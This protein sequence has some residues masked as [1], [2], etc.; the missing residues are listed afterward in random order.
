MY[1]IMFYFPFHWGKATEMNHSFN[2]I[3]K[4]Q[5]R[6]TRDIIM[7]TALI[8]LQF[9]LSNELYKEDCIPTGTSTKTEQINKIIELCCLRKFARIAGGFRQ[10]VT[11]SSSIQVSI[12]RPK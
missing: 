5:I 8:L 4:I 2:S 9:S 3:I 11:T 6:F 10:T 12:Y 1:A 7:S